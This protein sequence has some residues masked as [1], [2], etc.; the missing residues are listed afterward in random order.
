MSPLGAYAATAERFSFYH[1]QKNICSATPALF[2]DDA[3]VAHTWDVNDRVGAIN[4]SVTFVPTY[5]INGSN[6]RGPN[7]ST[8]IFL[9]VQLPA[10]VPWDFHREPLSFNNAQTVGTAISNPIATRWGVSSIDDHGFSN[11][12]SGSVAQYL[13]GNAVGYLT[14]SHGSELM[15]G[16]KVFMDEGSGAATQYFDGTELGALTSSCGNGLMAVHKDFMNEKAGTVAYNPGATSSASL[17]GSSLGM[18]QAPLFRATGMNNVVNGTSIGM[19]N[20]ACLQPETMDN[21][22]MAINTWMP[23]ITPNAMDS[24]NSGLHLGNVQPAMRF[25]PASMFDPN[26]TPFKASSTSPSLPGQTTAPLAHP[27][28]SARDSRT[29]CTFVGCNQIFRRPSDRLRHE[30]SVHWNMPGS[31]LCHV[32]GCPKSHGSGYKRAD[33]LTEHLWKKHPD[34]GFSKAS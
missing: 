3:N 29:R 33:K 1:G 5:D 18:T 16:H 24:L 9:D 14:S 25:S 7:A 12:Q 32:H 11:E 31:H 20:A 30:N 10:N 6:S 8:A 13:D 4:S 17:F 19:P 23:N 26:I 2:Q 28:P 21:F 22:G 15:T 34:L 27:Q